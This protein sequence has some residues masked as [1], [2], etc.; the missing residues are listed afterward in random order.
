MNA[1]YVKKIMEKIS[2]FK[3]ANYPDVVDG[4]LALEFEQWQKF[5]YPANRHDSVLALFTDCS[6]A[7]SAPWYFNRS[8]SDILTIPVLPT[9][10]AALDLIFKK[11]KFI[12]SCS[13][14]R[15]KGRNVARVYVSSR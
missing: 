3:Q 9:S 8:I 13:P 6:M 1:H 5:F 4:N 2:Q 10:A 15:S 7:I 14:T 12:Q 11:I